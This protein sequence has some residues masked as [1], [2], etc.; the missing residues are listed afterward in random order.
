MAGYTRQSLAQI[1]N[2]EI[3]SAPPLNAEFN[4]ILAAFNNSTGHKHDGTAAEGPPIDRIADSDQNNLIFVD[5]SANQ[6]NFYV[7]SSAASVGQISIQDGAIVPFTDNDIDLGSSSFEFKDLYIDGTANIDTLAASLIVVE[8]GTA[9]AASITTT[10]DTDNGLY[11]N[12]ANQMS[13]TSGGVAQVTFKDGSIVPVTDNDIDLGASGAEFKDLY[14][15]GTANIDSLVADTADINGGTIDNTV[16]GATTPAAATFTNLTVSTGSTINF[17]GATV[18]NGGTFTTVTISGG[19]ITGITDLAIADGGTG[20]STASAARTNLGV[21]IGTNV[22]AY[23]AGLQSISGLTTTA[24]QMIYTTSSDTYATTSL[25]SAGRALLDDASASAQRTTLGLGTLATQ[26]ANSVAITGGTISGISNLSDNGNAL[27]YTF[28]TTTTD[29]DPG[30]G[31]L[32]LNNATQNTATEIYIDDEEAN[33]A[34]VSAFIQLLS[35][36]NNPSSVL[37]T[38]TL[39][40]EF[41]SESFLQ[42]KVTGVT[43]ASGYTKLTIDNTSF[44]AASPFSNSDKVFLDIN[45][46]GDKGDP[47][48]VTGPA[49]STDNAV[50]RWDG[51][52][53]GLIQDSS[54]VIDDSGN[55]GI[56]TSS[57]STLLDVVGTI[58]AAQYDSTESLPDIKPSLNLDFANVKKLDPRIT[59]TRGSTATYYDGKTFAKAEENLFVDS[60]NFRG[61]GTNFVPLALSLVD[62]VDITTGPD[63]ISDA[64][65]LIPSTDANVHRV[66]YTISQ[67]GTYTVSLFVKP[68]GYNYIALS[69]AGDITNSV[70]FNITSGSEAVQS[71]NGT[72]SNGAITASG[73]GYFRISATLVL[74]STLGPYILVMSNATTFNFTGDGTSGIYLWGAQLEQRSALTD[75]TATTTQPITNYIPALQTAASGEPRFDH[76]PITGESKG[77]LIEEQR[78]NLLTYSEQFDNAAWTKG[79]GSTISANAAVA[80]NGE[81]T[82]DKLVES[83]TTSAFTVQRPPAVTGSHTFSV[84]AKAAERTWLSMRFS[85]TTNSDAYFNLSTGAVGFL[86]GCTASVV[87]FGDGWYRC[88]VTAT[89]A[90]IGDQV[91]I[92]LASANNTALYTGDGYSGIYIW[93]A[94]LEAGSFPTSYIPTV[95]SQVTRSPDAASMTGTN[96][97]SWYRQDEGAF[98]TAWRAPSYGTNGSIQRGIFGAYADINNRLGLLLTNNN[99][100]AVRGQVVASG[101]GYALIDNTYTANSDV[102]TV[103]AYAADDIELVVD[104]SSVGTDTSATLPTVSSFGIGNRAGDNYFIGTISR[105]VYWPKRLSNATLQ[106][107]TEE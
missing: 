68:N 55:V 103:L 31:V 45:L 97:S 82:A 88:I 67:T 92:R 21:A 42:F 53:G 1:L 76:D 29:S 91:V 73:N 13:Y 70:V 32:R 50:V 36:G 22:Q 39:R 51:T 37:G 65:A 102:R 38:I 2:G 59:F 40:K 9:S 23:D 100:N 107:L 95:A 3:V 99:P 89:V 101:T 8:A 43:N 83:G 49:S 96:F 72:A 94:Q 12:A 75:Y 34:D 7:E 61:S 41:S 17:S 52:S 74:G 71:T 11:F 33:A 106:A 18:S 77:F 5:T 15:D 6:I 10:G 58:T 81:T 93:G 47:G 64:D 63:G 35:G 4:Q 104:G 54:V 86:Y 85:G 60:E 27:P 69:S 28:S 19:S 90:G 80:P 98:Y 16:I 66:R 25:T 46:A 56:G 78:A 44:S 87:D 48:D 79:G 105:L 24:D 30:S 14:I 20:A 57:P 62:V 26:D 84:F